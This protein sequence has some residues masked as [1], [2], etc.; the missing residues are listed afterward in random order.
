MI[1][2][3]MENTNLSG[4]VKNANSIK[5]S[6]DNTAQNDNQHKKLGFH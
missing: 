5:N 1:E 6:V 3:S 2:D 4:D